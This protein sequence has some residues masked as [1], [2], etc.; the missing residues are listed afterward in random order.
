MRRSIVMM[1]LAAAV[2]V[3]A[4]TAA[5]AWAADATA[6]QEGRAMAEGQEEG[7]ERRNRDGHDA[8]ADP[9]PQAKPVDR[10]RL[11]REL[12]SLDHGSW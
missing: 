11:A 6:K 3:S 10:E 1:A 12:P 2:S 4:V 7:P 5:G 9:P 8:E